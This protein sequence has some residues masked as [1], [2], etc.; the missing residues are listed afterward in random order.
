MYDDMTASDFDLLRGALKEVRQRAMAPKE[1]IVS[2]NDPYFWLEPP[3]TMKAPPIRVYV[4]A[5]VLTWRVQPEEDGDPTGVARSFDVGARAQA[6]MS[7]AVD[8]IE[9]TGK[10][11]IPTMAA[12]HE[13]A[14]SDAIDEIIIWWERHGWNMNES[15]MDGMREV[16]YSVKHS[17]D[18]FTGMTADRRPVRV[19]P[20]G[21]GGMLIDFCGKMGAIEPEDVS[22]MAVSNAIMNMVVGDG[23]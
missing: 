23:I 5:G 9:D 20:C 10:D 7:D 22:T 6:I 1:F 2:N 13:R 21:D 17:G 3:A 11:M 4:L 16:L 8:D 18:A 14:I 15:V 19:S 12:V